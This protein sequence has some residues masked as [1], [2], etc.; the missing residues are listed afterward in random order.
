MYRVFSNFIA[1]KGERLIQ[2]SK[3]KSFRF[4]NSDSRGDV[5]VFTDKLV[6]VDEELREMS[7]MFEYQISTDQYPSIGQKRLDSLLEGE[8]AECT[9]FICHSLLI[10]WLEFNIAMSVL[11][12]R[13]STLDD[14]NPN[15]LHDGK[16]P[17]R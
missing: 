17:S 7:D 16:A 6:E 15:H 12:N 14:D 5:K 3:E 10:H 11:T 4:F 8:H 1:E 2:P 9:A 13:I